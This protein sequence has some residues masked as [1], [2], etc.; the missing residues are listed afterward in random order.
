M[1]CSRLIDTQF[2]WFCDVIEYTGKVLEKFLPFLEVVA[3]LMLLYA[4][5]LYLVAKGD[6]NK[7]N[8]SK[9]IVLTILLVAILIFIMEFLV[10]FIGLR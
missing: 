3:L 2:G 4:V 5:Y 8:L 7:I 10:Q 9:N 6:P 1:S